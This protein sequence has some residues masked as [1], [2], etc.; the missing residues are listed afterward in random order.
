MPVASPS[1]ALLDIFVVDNGTVVPVIK[2]STAAVD[3]AREAPGR[4]V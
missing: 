4:M 1:P 3:A 2:Y